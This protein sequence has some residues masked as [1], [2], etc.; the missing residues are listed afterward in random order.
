MMQTTHLLSQYQPATHAGKEYRTLTST[1]KRR[2][3]N[4]SGRRKRPSKNPQDSAI[5]R[6]IQA[7][8]RKKQFY[9]GQST[10]SDHCPILQNISVGHSVRN[11]QVQKD[12]GWNKDKKSESKSSFKYNTPKKQ[13]SNLRGS[14]MPTLQIAS[15]VCTWRKQIIPK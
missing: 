3:S 8:S 1:G 6:T 4:S 12:L 15:E 9:S 5:H 14:I 2:R 11:C 13:P 10:S 7:S